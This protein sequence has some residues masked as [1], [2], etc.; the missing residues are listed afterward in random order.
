MTF[1]DEQKKRDEF[2]KQTLEWKR[3]GGVPLE[4]LVSDGIWLGGMFEAKSHEAFVAIGP[5]NWDCE[6]DLTF[7][8]SPSEVDAFIE[9]LRAVSKEAFD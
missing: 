8:K 5:D 3:N 7:F 6:E 2:F 4:V 9:K 1:E